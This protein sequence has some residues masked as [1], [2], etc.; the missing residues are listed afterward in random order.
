MNILNRVGPCLAAI[1]AV[2]VGAVNARATP[3]NFVTVCAPL[4]CVVLNTPCV[5]TQSTVTVGIIGVSS[6]VWSGPAR[7]QTRTFK[8]NFPPTGPKNFYEYQVDLTHAVTDAEF[9]CITDLAI[10]FGPLIKLQYNGTGQLDHVYVLQ[11]SASAIGLLAVDQTN[12]VIT[13]TFSE[14]ICAGVTPGTGHASRVFGLASPFPPKAIVA[15]VSVPA[16]DPIDVAARAPQ[17]R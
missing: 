9:A 13:F 1:A 10:D 17:H 11:D 15:K 14:P 8:L 6:L 5:E 12:G 7:V 4:H 2:A 16:L 3:L